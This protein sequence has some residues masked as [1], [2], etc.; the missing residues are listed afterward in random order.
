MANGIGQQLGN[1][2]LVGLLGQ[3]GADEAD[4]T[5]GDFTVEA[6]AFADGVRVVELGYGDLLSSWMGRKGRARADR[7]SPGCRAQSAA[8]RPG[9]SRTAQDW[10]ENRAFCSQLRRIGQR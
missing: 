5:G 2:R 3:D 4:H 7:I 9:S 6:R 10:S 8:V 1:Y